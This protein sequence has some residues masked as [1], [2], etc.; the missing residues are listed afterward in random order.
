MGKKLYRASLIGALILAI[1]A[2]GGKA[3][4]LAVECAGCVA[5]SDRTTDAVNQ[6]KAELESIKEILTTIRDH[7]NQIRLAVGPATTTATT[8]SLAQESDFRNLL[9]LAPKVEG[10]S[11]DK[12]VSIDFGD[13]GGLGQTLNDSLRI[14][15]DGKRLKK[16]ITDGNYLQTVADIQTITNRRQTVYSRAVERVLSANFYSL[17][18]TEAAKQSELSLDYG[19]RSALNLQQKANAGAKVQLEIL[20]RLNHLIALVAAQNTMNGAGQL[21]EMEFKVEGLAPPPA[22]GSKT[23][24]LGRT[25]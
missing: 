6:V 19:R 21:K 18:Q 9:M 22:Q 7:L 2:W 15:M 12:G 3:N 1:A 8:G 16:A 10:F 17:S 25:Q 5:A 4:A 14:Y 24:Y 20:E 13:L 11:L 23:Q